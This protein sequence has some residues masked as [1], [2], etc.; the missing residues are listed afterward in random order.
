VQLAARSE[1][2]ME[3]DD[4][5]RKIERLKAN[6]SA[7]E[8]ALA[9]AD[10]ECLSA[11][12]NVRRALIA[13]HA[14]IPEAELLDEPVVHERDRSPPLDRPL[15]D[16]DNWHSDS[17]PRLDCHGLNCQI[18]FNPIQQAWVAWLG[19]TRHETNLPRILDTYTDELAR[20]VVTVYPNKRQELDLDNETRANEDAEIARNKDREAERAAAHE[21]SMA[22]Y[23]RP[24]HIIGYGCLGLIA[25]V[26]AA[27]LGRI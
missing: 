15:D 11:L 12:R 19:G 2:D 25:L 26:V 14:K 10:A 23:Y 24:L 13:I 6:V 1:A 21:A 4:V 22:A 17:Y 9:K 18:T 16:D 27:V 5:R 8:N 3:E 20:W 7:R